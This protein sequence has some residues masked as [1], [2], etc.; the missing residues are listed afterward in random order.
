MLLK[1]SESDFEHRQIATR[2]LVM[3]F[4]TSLLGQQSVQALTRQ[5]PTN[6]MITK[7]IFRFS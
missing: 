2:V 6:R 5:T 1:L 7:S 4:R 3:N